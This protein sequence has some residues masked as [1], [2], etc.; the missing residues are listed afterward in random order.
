MARGTRLHFKHQGPNAQALSQLNLR[1]AARC[2][3]AHCQLCTCVQAEPLH[4]TVLYFSTLFINIQ[5]SLTIVR[6]ICDVSHS[7]S[8][9]LGTSA[10][11]TGTK[12]TNK[13]IVA[14][15]VQPSSPLSLHL[16]AAP[17]RPSRWCIYFSQA[18]DT[19]GAKCWTHQQATCTHGVH[20]L[21]E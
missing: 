11:H 20:L 5:H 9:S 1:L 2:L 7:I 10:L 6:R 13:Y 16:C 14:E 21:L 15:H 18:R 3:R 17:H 4:L 12:L 19:Q 8:Q